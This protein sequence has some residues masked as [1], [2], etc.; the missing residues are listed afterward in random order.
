MPM[1]ESKMS[2]TYV[3]DLSENA[4]FSSKLFIRLLGGDGFHPAT[5]VFIT[6]KLFWIKS[7][8]QLFTAVSNDS[9]PGI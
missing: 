9:L 7:K 1:T 6:T 2:Y 8:H 4:N 5:L 3:T